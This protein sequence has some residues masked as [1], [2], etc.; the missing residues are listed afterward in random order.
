VRPSTWDGGSLVETAHIF[1]EELAVVALS[2]VPITLLLCAQVGF[3]ET[4]TALRVSMW[5]GIGVL[6]LAG[7]ALGEGGRL[8]IGGR[9]LSAA[10][11][12]ALGTGIVI[13][14][15]LFAH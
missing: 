1:T 4:E 12:A 7:W 14:E 10:L 8:A 9:F 2:L 6:A 5:G 13:L 11:C 15:L 3:L